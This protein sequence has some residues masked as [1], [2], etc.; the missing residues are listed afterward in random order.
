MGP[1]AVNSS[2]SGDSGFGP[3]R[4]GIIGEGGFECTFARVHS[5]WYISEGTFGESVGYRLTLDLT[6]PTVASP[7]RRDFYV[8][9]G[10]VV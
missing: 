6:P 7:L 4:E 9:Y 8:G 2:V 1:S 3:P 10:Q 5:R